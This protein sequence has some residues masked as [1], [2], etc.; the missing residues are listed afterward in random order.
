[1]ARL[2]SALRRSIVSV[3]RRA[4][5]SS[6]AHGDRQYIRSAVGRNLIVWAM[7][8]S[9]QPEL[10]PEVAGGPGAWR[11]AAS[12][13]PSH[14]ITPVRTRREA[15]GLTGGK[16]GANAS[17]FSPSP[18]G[19]QVQPFEPNVYNIVIF[20]MKRRD[21]A[22]I[23]RIEPLCG[24]GRRT[25]TRRLYQHG[26]TRYPEEANEERRCRNN[27]ISTHTTPDRSHAYGEPRCL[28]VQGYN[29]TKNTPRS[30]KCLAP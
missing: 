25:E 21:C 14:L 6:C 9:L 28:A 1:V 27:D 19:P 17:V 22:F 15:G 30:R 7:I 20:T 12:A 11:G 16:H 5:G 4:K 8:S 13:C 26:R 29:N 10:S 2:R 3:V 23:S 24:L 18:D